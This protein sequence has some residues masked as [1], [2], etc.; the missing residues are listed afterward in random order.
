MAGSSGSRLKATPI[1]PLAPIGGGD[2]SEYRFRIGAL[3]RLGVQAET[4]PPCRRARDYNEL[5]E[6]GDEEA[7]LMPNTALL[8]GSH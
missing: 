1:K 3:S 2:A 7:K 5:D 8:A 4:S 6:E